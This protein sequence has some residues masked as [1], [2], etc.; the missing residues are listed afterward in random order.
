MPVVPAVAWIILALGIAIGV[1]ILSSYL[2][3]AF[4]W[5]FASLGLLGGIF[6]IA[7]LYEIFRDVWKRSTAEQTRK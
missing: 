2:G 5:V 3:H 4:S 6:G 1:I 7:A